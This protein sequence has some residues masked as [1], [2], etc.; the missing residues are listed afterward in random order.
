MGRGVRAEIMDADYEMGRFI[1]YQR[2]EYERLGYPKQAAFA[3]DLSRGSIP[4]PPVIND[5]KMD[6][7]GSFYWAQNDVKRRIL[8]DRYEGESEEIRARR[9]S[10]SVRRLRVELDRLLTQFAGYLNGRG[11]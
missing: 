9:A 5:P 10:M 4:V 8:A 1:R 2:T 3:K 11:F 7:A 6:V